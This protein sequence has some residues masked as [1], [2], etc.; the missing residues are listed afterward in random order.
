MCLRCEKI[1]RQLKDYRLMQA[2]TD[3]EL[4]LSLFAEVIDDL[5]AE[6]ASL[7]PTEPRQ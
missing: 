1:E 6:K 5:E 3:D 2:R 7:H 4:A